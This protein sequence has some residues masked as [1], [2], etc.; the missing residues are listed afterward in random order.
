MET[1]N[2][3]ISIL[4]KPEDHRSG[5]S[6]LRTIISL[7]LFIAVDYWIFESWHAVL[8]LVSV[9]FIHEMG[10]FIAMKIFGYKNVNMTFVPFVGAYVSGEVVNFS[11]WNKL[12]VLLAGPLPGIIIG[13]VIFYLYNGNVDPGYL[14]A[15]IPFLLLNVFNLLPISPLDGGQ[16]FET[17]FF[18]SNHMLQLV[19]LYISLIVILYLVYKLQAYGFLL[20]ALLLFARIG[21][22]NLTA[23]VRKQLDENKIDYQCSYG[24]LT[25]EQYWQIRDTVVESSKLLSKKYAAGVPAENESVLI[26]YIK[27]C[28]SPHYDKE[29]TLTA[30]IIF[31]LIWLTAFCLPV[32]YWMYYK[33]LI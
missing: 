1:T 19:F 7:S 2:T 21:S 26:S 24:D 27:N 22:I 20:I 10:H 5:G 25:D 17:L 33:G 28:L 23:R 8:L 9:I 4:P 29:L 6:L 32:V 3:T 15:A 11:K 14:K 30:K 12:V 31:F 16:F 18:N 13:M